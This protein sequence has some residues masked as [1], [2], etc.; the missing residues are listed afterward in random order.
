MTTTEE[1]AGPAWRRLEHDERRSQI[2]SAARRLFTERPFSEVSMAD[3]A[4]AAGVTRGLLHHYFGGKRDLYLA[5]IRA[6]ARVPTMPL[7]VEVTDLPADE[8]W[9]LSVDA[10]MAMVEANNETWLMLLSARGPGRDDEVDAILEVARELVALRTLEALRVDESAHGP[11]L[12]ALVR[13]YGGFAE[14][15]V[16][17]W[18][19]RKRLTR[20]EVRTALLATLPLL[21]SQVLPEVEASSTPP[22][23]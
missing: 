13:G 11:A 9:A 19:Q 10:W 3:L 20:D 2:L 7:P 18:L 15:L 21:V 14:E 12:R 5:V 6:M 8:V 1:R 17:E 4:D 16:R 22:A 23:G